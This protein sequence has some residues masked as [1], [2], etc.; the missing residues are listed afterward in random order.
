MRGFILQSEVNQK[1][2]EPRIPK[3][4]VSG[5][6]GLCSAR[7]NWIP[8]QIVGFISLTRRGRNTFIKG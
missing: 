6:A 1:L 4:L 2:V 3:N 8:L 7:F 5:S